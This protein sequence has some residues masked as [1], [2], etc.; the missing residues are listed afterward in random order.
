MS[1]ILFGQQA[2]RGMGP[3]GRKHPADKGT[4]PLH[5]TLTGATMIARSFRSL[6]LGAADEVPCYRDDGT[7]TSQCRES[8]LVF[9]ALSELD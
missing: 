4:V 1:S 8:M 5:V 9:S 7:I 2:G 6:L 3:P